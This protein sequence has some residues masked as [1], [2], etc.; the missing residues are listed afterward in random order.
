MVD[1]IL[2][3]QVICFTQIRTCLDLAM[4]E[5]GLLHHNIYKFIIKI[6]AIFLRIFCNF[7]SFKVHFLFPFTCKSGFT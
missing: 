4:L 1:L 7:F 5:C 6:N 2:Y 3:C